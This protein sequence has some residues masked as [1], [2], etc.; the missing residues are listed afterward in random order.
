MR[1]SL[2][3]E[4]VEEILAGCKG[5]TPGPWTFT[6]LE[7]TANGLKI[8]DCLWG[9]KT[10]D[11]VATYRHIARLDPQT[12]SSLA[13]ELL[14]LRKRVG[15]L[16]AKLAAPDWYWPAEDTSEDACAFSASEVL[17]DTPPGKIVVVVRGGIV[18]TMY[19]AFLPAADDADSDDDF[20]VEEPTEE[21]AV[22][23]IA[24]ERVRRA[25]LPTPKEPS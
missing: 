13:T 25:A 11:G 16:E 6:G 10:S 12:V 22:L 17:D 14:A 20:W 23:K 2:T 4:Q 21:A 7:M 24:E 18:E 5:V 19:C 15:E 1:A 3:T 8:V 9:S